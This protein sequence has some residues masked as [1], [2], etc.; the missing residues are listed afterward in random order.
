M[1]KIMLLSVSLFA[2]AAGQAQADPALDFQT[3][4]SSSNTREVVSD[5]PTPGSGVSQISAPTLGVFCIPLG[6]HGN[7]GTGCYD[8]GLLGPSLYRYFR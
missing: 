7:R 8:F 6:C 4:V 3:F 2:F 5:G 1:K